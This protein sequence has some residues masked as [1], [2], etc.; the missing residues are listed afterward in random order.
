M[1]ENMHHSQYKSYDRAEK[2]TKHEY[3]KV[4]AARELMVVDNENHGLEQRHRLDPLMNLTI[5]LPYTIKTFIVRSIPFFSKLSQQH[6]PSLSYLR[7]FL[8]SYPKCLSLSSQQHTL[9]A[10]T[11]PTI[12]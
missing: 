7:G 12:T 8:R 9:R 3:K 1:S 2:K 6:M 4:K 11:N 10:P 5:T